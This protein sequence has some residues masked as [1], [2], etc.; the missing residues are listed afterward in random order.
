MSDFLHMGG[1]GLYV[2]GSF[3]V[4]AAAL[5]VEQLL[6]K[7]RTSEIVRSLRRRARAERM[8]RELA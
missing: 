8:D 7:R 3:G 1:Y 6:L 4:S 2:W 5:V